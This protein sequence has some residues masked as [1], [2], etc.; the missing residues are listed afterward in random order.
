M[1]QPRGLW[2][3]PS[4]P[5]LIKTV[6]LEN[7]C[8][9]MTNN[10]LLK[11][12]EAYKPNVTKKSSLSISIKINQGHL[13]HN[14]LQ[15]RKK[16]LIAFLQITRKDRE[17]KPYGA[18]D[19]STPEERNKATRERHH[20]LAG[21]LFL[22]L[23]FLLGVVEVTGWKLSSFTWGNG[24]ENMCVLQWMCQGGE[25]PGHCRWPRQRAS[26]P[27]TRVWP[28]ALQEGTPHGISIWTNWP[29]TFQ[30][31]SA[32]EPMRLSLINSSQSL[33]K[34]RSKAF[35]L[36]WVGQNLTALGP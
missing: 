19:P 36:P 22:F 11:S 10:G 3:L 33:L 23:D 29:V 25:S 26:D 35:V 27:Q 21:S 1:W 32:L 20:L 30:L 28:G 2:T 34:A 14:G 6:L 8:F 5:L 13:G 7:H 24:L 31:Q 4:V 12:Y 15:L 18:C 17:I 9:S 16:L